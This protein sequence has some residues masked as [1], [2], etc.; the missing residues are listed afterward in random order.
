MWKIFAMIS[1][2]KLHQQRLELGEC[3]K[4]LFIFSGTIHKKKNASVDGKHTRHSFTAS[5]HQ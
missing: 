1:R 4:Q 3:S 5:L 2:K